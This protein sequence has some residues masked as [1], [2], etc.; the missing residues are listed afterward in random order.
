[1]LI[2]VSSPLVS[3]VCLQ[4]TLLHCPELDL[5]VIRSG[6]Q[7]NPIDWSVVWLSCILRPDELKLPQQRHQDEEE[8]HTSQTLSDTHA[9]TCDIKNTSKSSTTVS[10]HAA[11]G[12]IQWD[13]Y[14]LLCCHTCGERHESLWFN[15]LSLL[16]EEVFRVEFMR[17]FPLSFLAQHWG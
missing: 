16:I 10:V 4:T 17:E 1:M 15:K 7:S 3:T 12:A 13:P 2:Y 14:C 9:R 8:F 11:A 6:T 5:H